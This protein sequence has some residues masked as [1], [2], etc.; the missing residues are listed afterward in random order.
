MSGPSDTVTLETAEEAPSGPPVDIRV[1]AVDQHTLRVAW[2]PPLREHWNGD[3]LGYYVGYKKTSH[4]EE[5]P[6][7]FETVEFIRE[8]AEGGAAHQLQVRM[9][10][11]QHIKIFLGCCCYPRCSCCWMLL[12]YTVFFLLL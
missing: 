8:E 3:I 1:S 4:G 10:K 7:Y 11:T 9:R 6:Y 2:K 5:K 12:F